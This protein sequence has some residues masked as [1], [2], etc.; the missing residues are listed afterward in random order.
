[1]TT[2]PRQVGGARSNPRRRPGVSAREE[3]RQAAAGLFSEHGYAATT[4]RGIAMAVG[5]KQASLYYHFATKE[6]ILAGLLEGTVQPS[7]S[8]SD[9][10]AHSGQPP[11][12]QLYALTRFDVALLLSG[13]WNVGALYQL[14]EVRSARFAE[15][16]CERARLRDAYGRRV[17]AGL[18]DG[19]FHHVESP[20]VITKLVF[21]LAESVISMRDDSPIP[22][23]P[24]LSNTIAAAC[25]RVLSCAEGD[26]AEAVAQSVPLLAEAREWSGAR[27]P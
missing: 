20:K 25:L 16:R 26:L 1:V 7:L 27:S 5:I 11:H 2:T 23:P 22:D 3:I 8:F 17:V 13:K 18:A 6:D 12:V 9:R 21:A 24:E 10:L 14:P 4:T 15:F 19:V